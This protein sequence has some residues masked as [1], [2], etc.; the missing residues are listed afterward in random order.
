MAAK[1][2]KQK[3][4]LST[5]SKWLLVGAGGV[6][7][8][9]LTLGLVYLLAPQLF[10]VVVKDPVGGEGSCAAKMNSLADTAV[11][12]NNQ[13][14]STSMVVEH[15]DDTGGVYSTGLCTPGSFKCATI[16]IDGTTKSAM[17]DIC[18]RLCLTSK[19]VLNGDVFNE[20][21]CDFYNISYEDHDLD[22]FTC[23]FYKWGAQADN[24]FFDPTNPSAQEEI[25]ATA[26]YE[27][28]YKD[29]NCVATDKDGVQA[30][31]LSQI[32]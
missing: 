19:L 22:R 13:K 15:E 29:T 4:G 28:H 16:T 21:K 26:R 1:P 25:Q 5:R 14:M 11:T 2:K 24:S 3:K 6:F 31:D 8:V 23:S 27:L 9:L 7:L 18:D 20:T 10:G 32:S 12:Y 17:V 30:P